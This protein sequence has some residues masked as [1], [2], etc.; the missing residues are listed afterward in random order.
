MSEQPPWGTT[1]PVPPPPPPGPSPYPAPGAPAPGPPP[2]G[3]APSYAPPPGAPSYPQAQ[4]GAWQPYPP[5]GGPQPGWAPAPPRP[6]HK[7]GAIPLR[8]LT[9]GDFYGAAFKI[10]RVNAKATVGSAVLVS[11]VAMLLPVLVAAGLTWGTSMTIDPNSD[12]MGDSELLGLAGSFGALLV[13]IVLQSF[14]MVLVTGMVAHVVVAAGQGRR[15]SL[16]EAWAATHG[17]RWRLVALTVLIGIATTAV[18]LLFVGLWV[19]AG[20]ELDLALALTVIALTLPVFVALLGWAWTRLLYLPVPALM[21]ERTGVFASMGRA[22]ALTKGHF[23]R[24]LGIALL[25]L[26]I[27]QMAGSML[28]F[29]FTLGGQLVSLFSPEYALLGFVGGQAVGS[30]VTAAIAY[31]FTACVTTLQYVDLR[32]RKEGYDLELFGDAGDR[33]S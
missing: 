26:M 8:P 12:T 10:I 28:A 24:T 27:V 20:A 9:L 22:F 33:L 16:G 15:M 32:I 29:P 21:V 7:P 1:G 23:W 2:P 6:A 18:T 4:P 3:A 17:A 5:Q 25:T 13:G 19:L 14:G 30:V 31:P 11:A